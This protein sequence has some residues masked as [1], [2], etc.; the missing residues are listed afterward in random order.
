MALLAITP[1]NAFTLVPPASDWYGLAWSDRAGPH[2][3]VAQCPSS[4]S[5]Q[6]IQWIN[7]NCTELDP[8]PA[9]NRSQLPA[10]QLGALPEGSLAMRRNAGAI[11]GRAAP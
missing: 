5:G 6:P 7:Q 8:L 10:V 3:V 11:A 9:M 4:P 2:E 1:A